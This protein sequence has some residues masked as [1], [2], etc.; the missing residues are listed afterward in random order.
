MFPPVLRT[1]LKVW[2]RIELILS[3]LGHIDLDRDHRLVVRILLRRLDRGRVDGRTAEDDNVAL[4]AEF[5][6]AP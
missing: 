1:D 3:R 4:R 2:P 5:G 6:G